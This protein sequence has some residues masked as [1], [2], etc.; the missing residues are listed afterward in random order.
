MKRVA[1]SGAA[2]AATVVAI[3]GALAAS[4]A[5]KFVIALPNGYEMSR[6]KSGAVVIEKRRGKR[7][8]PGPIKS[9]TVV[10]D[11]VVGQ[12][13]VPE[14]SEAAEK[15]AGA[16][17]SGA[18][19]APETPATPAG[20]STA[21]GTS[22]SSSAPAPAAGAGAQAPSGAAAGAAPGGAAAPA[23]GGMRPG[24]GAGGRPPAG[25]GKPAADKPPANPV[26]TRP[27]PAPNGRYFVLDTKSG[28]VDKDLSLSEWEERLKKLDIASAP[29]LAAPILPK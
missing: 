11:V 29:Q 2:L 15:N 21:A 4:A 9:Y 7:V 18:P 25:G 5:E 1:A 6:V 12:L 13:D 17:V 28:D 22:N 24:G 26:F 14:P 19:S 20:G 16:A 8:V 23:G 3:A 27:P 10:R